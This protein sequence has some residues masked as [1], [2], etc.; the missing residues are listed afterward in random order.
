M[1]KPRCSL[2]RANI[3]L[4]TSFWYW[5]RL[6]CPL[7]PTREKTSIVLYAKLLS[8]TDTLDL[9]LR[10]LPALDVFFPDRH[11]P[12]ALFP[13]SP[14]TDLDLVGRQHGRE[15][16]HGV[17]VVGLVRVRVRVA[18]GTGVFLAL[19]D[20]AVRLAPFAHPVREDG[21]EEGPHERDAGACAADAR[22]E[23]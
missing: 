23:H 3:S 2:L 17:L 10:I 9:A 20:I 21:G 13:R 7:I 15:R 18:G 4:Y 1:T 11:V 16:I 8:H 5:A 12:L 14:A 22:L 19:G 6:P